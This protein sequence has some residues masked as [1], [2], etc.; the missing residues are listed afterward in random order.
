MRRVVIGLAVMALA[1]SG[2]G[3][4]KRKP[5]EQ[6]RQA[7]PSLGWH[8]ANPTPEGKKICRKRWLLD[9]QPVDDIVYETLEI[10]ADDPQPE[11]P[12][13]IVPAS[14][15]GQRWG[16]Q[17]VTQIKPLGEHADL[18][19]EN[20]GPEPRKT[21]NTVDAWKTPMKQKSVVTQGPP[22]QKSPAGKPTGYTVQLAAFSSF[23]KCR[24]FFA[25]PKFR[26]APMYMRKIYS[27]GS[28][29]WIVTQGEY[30][31]FTEAEE[32]AKQLAQYYAPAVPWA[33]SWAVIDA[34]Q[35]P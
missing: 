32:V 2:C 35:K 20:L 1:T 17:S 27:E 14:D 7:L 9:G 31:T 15:Q 22:P 28:P 4:L 6:K 33:R 26:G 13:A 18:G 16:R 24:A 34:L 12:P 25:S 3:M 5:A 29:W 19:V 10:A 11:A 8:C 21:K 23:D 30:E